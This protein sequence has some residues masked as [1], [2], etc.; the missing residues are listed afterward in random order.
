MSLG[1]SGSLFLAGL[2]YAA[3]LAVVSLSPL[4][5]WRFI[6]QAPW[7][8]LSGPWP[9]YWTGFDVLVNVIAYAPLGVF[10]SRAISLRQRHTVWGPFQA[11]FLSIIVGVLL[12]VL[13]EGLQTYLPSRRPS[14]LDVIANGVGTL[15]GA[16]LAS[17]YAQGSR[18]LQITESRPIEIGGL[19][20]LG[21]WFVA[22]ASP[23][24]IWLAL[25]DIT[26]NI[27]LGEILPWFAAPPD[28]SAADVELFAAQ[29]ILVEALCVATAIMGC[30][31]LTHLTLLESPRWW[32]GYQANYWVRTFSLIVVLTLVIRAAWVWLLL[33][34][35]ALASWLNAGTQ[36]GIVLTLLSAYGFAGARPS[37]Q[38][39]VAILSLFTTVFLA[40]SVPENGYTAATTLAWSQGQWLNLQ[41][42]ANTAA[43]I[44]P[45][46]ALVWFWLVIS[47]HS[48]RSLDREVPRSQMEQ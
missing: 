13:L 10:I 43:T 36:A 23:Q 21:L 48:A 46:A 32:P 3:G 2:L 45:F 47:R 28:P 14:I 29:R 12:S 16:F 30:A 18:R 41:M 35:G 7:E 25:G 27:A 19:M 38:R 4:T 1:R 22:Q 15:V 26:V 34:P 42:L 6:P 5:D 17:A 31:L 37:Q 20:L 33:G 39:I 40:N 24:P 11:F 9:R 8:F 44:W